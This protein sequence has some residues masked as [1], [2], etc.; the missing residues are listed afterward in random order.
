MRSGRFRQRAI[1]WYYGTTT[2]LLE[3]F[4]YS[5]GTFEVGTL[6]AC[7]SS[8]LVES[9]KEVSFAGD[10]S[11]LLLPP[12][13][14]ILP[15]GGA[16]LSALLPPSSKLR[17]PRG[18]HAAHNTG[19]ARDPAQGCQEPHRSR[20]QLTRGN[21]RRQILRR[22]CIRQLLGVSSEEM[23]EK[24]IYWVCYAQRRGRTFHWLRTASGRLSS[25]G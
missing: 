25:E 2:T 11:L 5:V 14:R 22:A 3:T 21:V 16:G 10:E 17:R 6:S 18:A 1:N 20:S 15:E 19:Q 8:G 9:R 7:R 4:A 23:R 24:G 12:P 13:Q